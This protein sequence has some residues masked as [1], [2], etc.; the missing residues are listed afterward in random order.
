MLRLL[1]PLSFHFG[2]VESEHLC[3]NIPGTGTFKVPVFFYLET[4]M[5]KSL[6]P[7]PQKNSAYSALSAALWCSLAQNQRNQRTLLDLRSH[8]FL[9]SSSKK[10]LNLIQF[11]S[12]YHW[13]DLFRLGQFFIHLVN[14]SSRL[15]LQPCIIT[16]TTQPLPVQR[17]SYA[18]QHRDQSPG[19][20]P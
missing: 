15:I 14:P 2:L 9:C 8:S 3:Y 4:P 16:P 10:R 12:P 19:S 13:L 18:P 17:I 6:L 11:P 7:F 20:Q 1:S 5:S